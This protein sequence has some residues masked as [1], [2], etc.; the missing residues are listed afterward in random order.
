MQKNPLYGNENIQR[1]LEG[2]SWVKE[3]LDGC[4]DFLDLMF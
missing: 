1:V 3:S 2:F 4:T